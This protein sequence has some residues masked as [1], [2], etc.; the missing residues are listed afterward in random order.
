[1]GIDPRIGGAIEELYAERLE[2]HYEILL[3]TMS[4]ARTT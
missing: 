4:G 3:T 1:V 2:D